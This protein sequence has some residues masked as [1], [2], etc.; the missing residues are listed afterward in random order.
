ME[1]P[2]K[3]NLYIFRN[4]RLQVLK[5]TFT[6]FYVHC[7]HFRCYFVAYI[8]AFWVANFKHRVCCQTLGTASIHKTLSSNLV[9]TNKIC[10]TGRS[11]GS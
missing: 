1:R 2:P 5:H 8:M 4:L 11:R 10:I 9:K 7:L 6:Q 3:L